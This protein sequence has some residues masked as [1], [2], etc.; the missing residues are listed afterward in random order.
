ML[1]LRQATKMLKYTINQRTTIVQHVQQ[2]VA[3]VVGCKS[4]AKQPPTWSEAYA[5]IRK[6][7]ATGSGKIARFPRDRS[8][9]ARALTPK[10]RLSWKC[11]NSSSSLPSRFGVYVGV[12]SWMQLVLVKAID[13]WNVCFEAYA[14]VG[15]CYVKLNVSD[16][17]CLVSHPEWLRL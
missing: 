5:V 8:A 1:H 7:L 15:I 14:A 17:L 3:A 6:L 4:K 2:D 12:L 10:N 11:G 9:G 16:W 13:L